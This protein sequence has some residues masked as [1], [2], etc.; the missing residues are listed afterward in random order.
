[1][2]GK[3]LYEYAR[4]G[5]PLPRPIEARDA[6][7][8]ELELIDWQESRSA[9][10]SSGHTYTWPT[11]ELSE[12]DRQRYQDVKNLIVQAEEQRPADS[13]APATARLLSTTTTTEIPS[14]SSSRVPPTFTLKMTVSSGT[15][16]RSI[17]HDLGL[18]LG[19]AAHVVSLTRTRQGDFSLGEE[20]EPGS[21]I[22]WETFEK[23]I[24]DQQ[25]GVPGSPVSAVSDPSKRAAWETEILEKW[26]D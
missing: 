5:K 1:M 9:E 3:P 20:A 19:S 25:N 2:D 7:V 15:Y 6:K 22:S 23:A 17:V 14:P 21:C 26:H 12:L 4:A 16:V 18:A 24:E 11:K 8:L 10:G 13:D